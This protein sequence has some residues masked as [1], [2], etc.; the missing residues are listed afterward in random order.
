MKY[1]IPKLYR[2]FPFVTVEAACAS[3][4]H[5]SIPPSCS[6]G[7]EAVGSGGCVSGAAASGRCLSGAAAG[8][9]CE[10]GAGY[11]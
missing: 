5:A 6:N 4:D 2:I 7:P 1:R 3:G 9:K 11:G 10:A 8:L